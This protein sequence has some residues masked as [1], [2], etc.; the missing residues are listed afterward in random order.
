VTRRNESNQKSLTKQ[1]IIAH[2]RNVDWQLER[3]KQAVAVLLK[4]VEGHE[5]PLLEGKKPKNFRE[6]YGIWK[7]ANFTWEEIQAAKYKAKEFLR[8]VG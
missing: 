3:L 2:L 5:G 6:L 4:A 1:E 7:G 8:P